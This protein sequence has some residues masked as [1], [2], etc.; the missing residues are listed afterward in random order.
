M[1]LL[2]LW[3]WHLHAV[4][5]T[6][7]LLLLLLLLQVAALY[8]CLTPS[9]GAVLLLS[10]SAL[11]PPSKAWLGRT[12]AILQPRMRQFST[13]DVAHMLLALGRMQ[14]TPNP[15]WLFDF[16]LE[17]RKAVPRMNKQ[18]LLMSAEA[19]ALLSSNTSCR[20]APELL[21]GVLARARVLLGAATPNG[22]STGGSSYGSSGEATDGTGSAVAA[23]VAPGTDAASEPASSTSSSGDAVPMPPSPPSFTA[24]AAAAAAAS[25]RTGSFTPGDCANLAQTLVHLK[26]A[27]GAALL[28]ALTTTF[29]SSL[30][31][32][33]GSQVA[34]MLWALG[35][36]WRG[37]AECLWLRH[38][39]DVIGALAA[40]A[41]RH[42]GEYTPLQLKRVLVA[43]ASMGYSPG[44]NWLAAHEAAV[45]AQLGDL[46][47]KTLQQVVRAYRD[48]GYCPANQAQLLNALAA[49]AAQQQQLPQAHNNTSSMRLSSNRGLS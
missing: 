46:W 8:P 31:A 25:N 33:S 40:A 38:H 2:V 36:W 12:L 18:Q 44:P 26:V 15:D 14:A 28:S 10:L 16:T 13:L 9:Y 1:V 30:Q 5:A 37:N 24:A 45:V 19:L 6:I 47:P 48:L 32:A 23:A 42:L 43:L 11:A 39:P 41:G 27:P 4:A 49:L 34:V 3:C 29:L 17:A 21:A 22:G 7:C 20:L 35:A